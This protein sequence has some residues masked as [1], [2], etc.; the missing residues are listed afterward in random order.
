ME[1]PIYEPKQDLKLRYMG[2]NLEF[3]SSEVMK[4]FVFITRGRTIPVKS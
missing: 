2:V 1:E 3:L 4:D